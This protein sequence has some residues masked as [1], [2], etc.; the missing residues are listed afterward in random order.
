MQK[1]AYDNMDFF[2]KLGYVFSLYKPSFEAFKVNWVTIV[3]LWLV[4]LFLAMLLIIFVFIV[5][6]SGDSSLLNDTVNIDWSPA[7][8][9]S[10]VAIVLAY[11]LAILLIWPAT[12]AT[13]LASVQKQK[14]SFSQAFKVSSKN[15]ISVVVVSILTGLIAVAPFMLVIPLLFIIV[16][17]LLLPVVFVWA[18]LVSFMLFIAPYIVVHQNAK[19][20]DALKASYQLTKANWQW[21]LAVIVV[22]FAV[23]LAGQ[24]LSIIPFIGFL[25]GIILSVVY[26]CLPA[27]VFI[28]H[29]NS[30]TPNLE[31][32]K[33][34][35][36][37]PL[38][39]TDQKAKSKPNN[40]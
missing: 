6:F 1:S 24:I 15:L 29:I 8:I 16:G 31:P 20:I 13:Q 14:I 21:V 27:Y 19:P 30:N 5:I 26:Y 39:N 35:S 17:F 2:E 4:P 22:L 11:L 3:L 38:K 12:I 18:T 40:K 7:K 33:Y 32:T 9:I 25:A 34:L 36:A 10:L 28:Y 23:S 37:S